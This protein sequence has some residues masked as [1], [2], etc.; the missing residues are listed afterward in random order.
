MSTERRE[1]TDAR[2][3]RAL[4]HPTR[5][6]LLDL[7]RREEELTASRAAELL[8]D[9]PGN[10]SWHF[11]TLAKY[12]FVEETG[13]GKGRS[14]PW[15]IAAVRNR[16]ITS[17]DDPEAAAAGDALVLLFVER[18]VQQHRDWIAVHDDYPPAW[19]DAA[20]LSNSLAYLTAAE[21]AELSAEV[22]ELFARHTDRVDKRKRPADALPVHLTA[23]GHPLPPTESGN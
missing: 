12:G 23:F 16:F 6:A 4:A 11:Q 14:R 7:L 18:A 21:L 1:I 15:R 5:L 2:T 10:M 3:M 19:Q 17:P 22:V 13:D 8:D 20:F 9:S